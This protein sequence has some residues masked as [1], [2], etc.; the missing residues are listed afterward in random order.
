MARRR[1]RNLAH[2]P[3]TINLSDILAVQSCCVRRRQQA[4]SKKHHE[5]GPKRFFKKIANLVQPRSA[6]QSRSRATSAAS[7]TRNAPSPAPRV[8]GDG[9]A[10]P[11]RRPFPGQEAKPNIKIRLATFNMGNSLPAPGGDLSEFLGDLSTFPEEHLA[12]A[13]TR[14][15][16]SSSGASSFFSRAKHEHGRTRS[17]SSDKSISP[18]APDLPQFPLTAAHPYHII[19][20]CGQEC[21]T[22]RSGGVFR[23]QSWTSQ[24]ENFLCGGA[25][26]SDSSDDD[27]AAEHAKEA[28][29]KA[30]DEGASKSPARTA[31][32]PT[33]SPNLSAPDPARGVASAPYTDDERSAAT[34]TDD[35]ASHVAPSAADTASISSRIRRGPYV[36][37]EKERLMGIYCAVFVARC[38]EDLVEGVSRSRVTAGLIGGRVGNKGGVG[39]SLHFASTRLLFVS[40][41]LAAHASGLEIRKANARKI[42]DELDVDDFLETAGPKPKKLVDRFDHAFFMGDLNF[43]LNI[44][45]LHADWLVQ[46]KDFTNALQFDQ[47]RAIL[48]ESDSA[49]GGFGEAPIHFAPTYKYDL[50]KTT[51]RLVHKPSRLL[52]RGSKAVP[53]QPPKNGQPRTSPHESD[54]NSVLEAAASPTEP[55]DDDAASI[56]S[57]VDADALDA[58]A[59]NQADL[60]A[61]DSAPD[62]G[63]DPIRNAR[64]R[65]L[66][67]VKHNS[68]RAA[69]ETARIRAQAS[70]GRSTDSGQRP[71]AQMFQDADEDTPSESPRSIVRQPQEA[72]KAGAAGKDTLICDEEPAWDSSKKQRVQSWTDRILFYPNRI[73][74]AKEEPPA[75][76]APSFGSL[77]RAHRTRSIRSLPDAGKRASQSRNRLRRQ[78]SQDTLAS[79]SVWQRVKSF[80]ALAI[81]DRP[82]SI[83]RPPSSASVSAPSNTNMSEV[84]NPPPTTIAARRAP[85]RHFTLS[86]STDSSPSSSP[87]HSPAAVTISSPPLAAADDPF[88]GSA[89]VN[90]P[91]ARTFASALSRLHERHAEAPDAGPSLNSRFRSFLTSLPVALPFLSAP[92]SDDTTAPDAAPMEPTRIVGPDPGELLPIEYNSVMNIERMGA[93]SDHRPVYLVCALG[94]EASS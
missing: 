56:A 53:I 81:L 55:A 31:S 21:P 39:I 71:L 47:L 77:F 54:T 14:G 78:V 72:V 63:A 90:L 88:H 84:E 12:R 45:R 10:D 44:S 43:R 82:P 40:A 80:P 6:R 41:H 2:R 79:S 87:V 66:T 42:L 73:A 4:P 83:E 35:L 20:V 57:T 19:V 92:V 18:L 3:R 30:L 61:S 48:G 11:V 9:P 59:A 70:R 38:C 36:L 37:V 51:R 25:D 16:R 64:V 50:R 52:R 94:V 1:F 34:S 17:V 49:L 13:R 74:T 32:P 29:T 76:L 60:P 46:A 85:R 68:T 58:L 75:P 69:L 67:L 7:S 65:F 86:G 15:K 26:E 5:A 91:R 89:P 22:A 27:E 93:V 62:N 23:G 8:N 33:G 24:L 28:P